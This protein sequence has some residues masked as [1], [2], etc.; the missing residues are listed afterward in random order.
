[1]MMRFCRRIRR[2]VGM[3]LAIFLLGAFAGCESEPLIFNTYWADEF[4][5]DGPPDPARWTYE[6]GFVRNHEDQWY[7]TANAFCAGG[8]LI[9][10]ARQ[11]HF[12]NPAYVPG[13]TDWRTNREFV[14]Y[15]SSSLLTRG[16]FEFQYGR[17][18]M[19]A[20]IDTQNGMW[21]AFWTLG[22]SGEWP[23]CGE[24]DIMEYYAGKILANGASGTGTRWQAKWDGASKQLTAFA[25][26]D[27]ADKFHVWT[28]DWN[29]TTITLAVDGEA[30]NT[31]NITAMANAVDTWGPWQPFAQ[32]HYL[33]LNLAIGGDCGG[34]PSGSAFPARYEIDYVRIWTR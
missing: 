30:L 34:D 28:M 11:D 22:A 13:S 26:P 21:P 6:T 9:I 3:F 27:W 1:M 2:M 8:Y 16:L 33:I 23:S 25:D 32:P 5:V 24:V 19:R 17:V 10:E 4:D 14:D 18:E 20:R 15:T 31:I 29:R 7:Q 12:A